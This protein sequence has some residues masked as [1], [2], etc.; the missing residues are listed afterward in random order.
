MGMKVKNICNNILL[1]SVMVLYLLILF[2]LLFL[3]RKVGSFQSLNLIPFRSITEYLFSDDILSKSFALSNI[4]GNVVIFVPLGLY[5]MLMNKNKSIIVNTF[6]IALTSTLVEVAQFIFKVGAADID[7][8]ILN[9]IG[10]F[11][12]AILFYVIHL[13]FK[14]KTKSAISLIA[15]IGGILA[16]TILMLANQ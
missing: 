9:T 4:L 5:I 10:G 8:V 12:G 15:P 3:K 13:I 6:I 11:I 2:A 16:F 14:S 7:D 1:Y